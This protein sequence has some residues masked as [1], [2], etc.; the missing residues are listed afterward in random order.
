MPSPITALAAKLTEQT[1]FILFNYL[2]KFKKA[3]WKCLDTLLRI[4]LYGKQATM[5][6]RAS[7]HSGENIK[8]YGSKQKT[9]HIAKQIKGI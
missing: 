5:E 1:W 9:S 4:N 7:V 2:M 3:N 6:S 8:Q